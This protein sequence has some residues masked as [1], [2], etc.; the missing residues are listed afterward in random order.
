MNSYPQHPPKFLTRILHWFCQEELIEDVEG[1]LNELFQQRFSNGANKAKVLYLFDVLLLFR[2]GIIKNIAFKT[3]NNSYSMFKNYLIIAWRNMMK[4][5]GFSSI[6]I[7]GLAIGMAACMVIYLFVVDELSFDQIHEKNV[8]RL[9]E[10]QSFPGTNTQKVALS[11]PGMGPTLLDEF[12]EVENFTRY[13]GYG[14]QLVEIGDQKL[15]VDHVSGVDTSFFN[16]FDYPLIH[17]DRNTVL[18]DLNTAVISESIAKSLFNKVD[19][20]GETFRIDEDLLKI[21]GVMKDIP[22]NSHL[23]FDILLSIHTVGTREDFD[24]QFGS[25]YLNT[26][27]ILNKSADLDAMAQRY[28]DYLI[29]HMENPDINDA[30]KMWMQPLKDV[31][32]ASS[33]IE[34]DYQNYRKFN[35]SYINVFILI[36]A[37]ILI[38]A[39]VNFMNLNTA[40]ANYRLKEIGVRK[41]IGA[42]R[43]QLFYQFILESIML[44][45]IALIFAFAIDL[46]SL[47]F[48]N[49][50]I[51]RSFSLMSILSSVNI[52]LIIVV[53]TAVLGLI[54]GLYPALYLSAFKPIVVLKGLQNYRKSFGRS[55]LIVFQFSLALGM[56]VCTMVVLQQLLYIKN[57]DIGYSKDHIML[58]SLKDQG[59]ANYEAMKQDLLK[60]SNVLGVTA[61]GQRIGNNFH[62][63]GFKVEV[64]TGIYS[65]TPSNVFVDHD[66]LDVYDIELVDGRTFSRE[67]T[68][69]DGLAFII[70]E[71]MSK[72]IGLENPVGARAAH[73]WYPNDS[74]GTIIGVT[75]DFNF[76]SLHYKVNN[77]VISVHTDWGYSEMSVKL[78][79][80]NIKQAI[81]DVEAIYAEHVPDYPI[82]YEFLDSHFEELY[83]SD[84]QM[85]VVISI[86]AVLSIFI[87]CMGLFG[88]ASIAIRR[89]IKEIGIRKVMGAS[90]KEI[91]LLLSKNFAFMILL[92]FIIATPLTILFLNGWL[93]NFAYR[94]SINPLI[95]IAGGIISLAIALITISVHVIKAVRSNPVNALRYE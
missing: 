67:H 47:P 4:Y 73:S 6:N 36:G 77:L 11:M 32:L 94:I 85:G 70:N 40:R 90:S 76:N 12:P 25:N 74:L 39:T 37:F 23:Q 57:K 26:Y 55:A 92:S 91:T 86:I 31:H 83:K 93:E 30:Y 61:S 19:V 64:D 14:K 27:L 8:Y 69:D 22:E 13:W 41:T 63:W 29:K 62:Q 49:S 5:K 95:F 84:Q 38:I 52:L 18:D 51:D 33:D 59:R 58:I 17:G 44:A 48:L 72:E 16:I 9:C 7:F 80:K 66:Y 28:P 35:G 3:Q 15:L 34:H 24:S 78:N 65:M 20:V 10:V 75:K 81:N 82:A 60:S 21:T 56:I 87:G 88:L 1:D 50:I 79:G 53:T 54:S 89:R 71:S 68:K 45:G 2:P 43:N 42:K 46:L